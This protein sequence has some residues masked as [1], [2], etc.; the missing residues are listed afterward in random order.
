MRRWAGLLLALCLLSVRPV[1]AV[2]PSEMLADPVLEERARLISKQVRC[3]V[4]QNESIDESNAELARDLRVVIRDQIT[5]GASD[6]QI[7][8]FLV[9]RYG[10]FILLMPPFSWQTL[11]LWVGPVVL[12]LTGG[13]LAILYLRGRKKAPAAPPL[14]D[15]EKRRLAVLLKDGDAP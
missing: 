6:E 4:C 7:F 15:E 11:I 5:K 3:V 10:A 13:G 9:D 8:T 2:N 1:W 14:S 12:L